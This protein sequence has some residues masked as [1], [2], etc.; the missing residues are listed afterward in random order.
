[1]CLFV[2]LLS[3]N[4]CVCCYN[5]CAL[6]YLFSVLLGFMCT[7]LYLHILFV[8]V[9]LR[10][11]GLIDTVEGFTETLP[12]FLFKLSAGAFVEKQLFL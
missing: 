10:L 5:M 9:L 7:C 11:C 8:F 2:C 3:V 6:L 12:E 1:M 4:L